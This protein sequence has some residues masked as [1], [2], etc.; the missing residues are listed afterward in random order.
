MP[1]L[2]AA[3][4]DLAE[5]ALGCK[6]CRTRDPSRAEAGPV[7]D[8]RIGGLV[9]LSGSLAALEVGV[10]ATPQ[11]CRAL[12][13]RLLGKPACGTFPDS[14]VRGAMCELAYLL[15]G[16]VKRRMAGNGAGAIS[17]GQPSF[18]AGVVTPKDGWQL[19]TTEVELDTITATL[20]CVVRDDTATLC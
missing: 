8:E 6:T 17:V 19:Q 15:A 12:A 2:F 13:E 18:F 9:Q 10:L 4:C 5:L 16:G 20:V 3:L 1:H 11:D 7:L 14:V